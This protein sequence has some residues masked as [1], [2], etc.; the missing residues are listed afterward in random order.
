MRLS[1]SHYYVCDVQKSEPNYRVSQNTTDTQQ[2]V[3]LHEY[4]EEHIPQ[5]KNIVCSAM[6]ML[7]WYS[8]NTKNTIFMYTRV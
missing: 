8:M 1:V 5:K 3:D 4:I 2:S 6:S 7:Y